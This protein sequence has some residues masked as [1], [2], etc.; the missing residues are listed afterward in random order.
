MP[1]LIND[2]LTF[3][4]LKINY[5]MTSYANIIYGRQC[6]RVLYKPYDILHKNL[7]NIVNLD[8]VV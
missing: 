7:I 6:R 4:K 2:S 5:R 1:L 3:E 8:V